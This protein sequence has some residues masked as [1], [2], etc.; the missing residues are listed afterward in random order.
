MISKR[1]IMEF[2]RDLSLDPNIVEKDYV[3]GWLN[4]TLVK[5]T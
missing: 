4:L 3:L 2:A 1:E 5:S